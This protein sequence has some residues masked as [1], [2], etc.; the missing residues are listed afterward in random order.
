MKSIDPKLFDMYRYHSYFIFLQVEREKS[1]LLCGY[2]S[3]GEISTASCTAFG[4]MVSSQ[5]CCLKES[6]DAQELTLQSPT[7]SPLLGSLAR[8]RSLVPA[9]PDWLPSACSHEWN[10]VNRH[11]PAALCALPAI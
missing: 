1:S 6:L 5:M 10:D 9:K 7:A 3:H 4:S 2:F 11:H 8:S